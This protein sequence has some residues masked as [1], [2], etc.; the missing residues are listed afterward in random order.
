MMIH[1]TR[2]VIQLATDEF[3][4]GVS[5]AATSFLAACWIFWSI[6]KKMEGG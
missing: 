6:G 1:I 3:A 2:F 5:C 4:I